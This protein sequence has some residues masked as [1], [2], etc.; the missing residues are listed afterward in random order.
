MHEISILQKD[1][2]TVG[3]LKN[4]THYCNRTK[5]IMKGKEKKDFS[6]IPNNAIFWQLFYTQM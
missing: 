6:L 5:F 2:L 4:C 1:P 3:G